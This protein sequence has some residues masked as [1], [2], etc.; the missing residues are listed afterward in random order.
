MGIGRIGVSIGGIGSLPADAERAAVRE[1][2]QLGYE[3][4]WYSESNQTR[5][6]FVHGALLLSWT[7]SIAVASSIASIWARDAVAA[8]AAVRSLGE[9]FPGRFVCGLGV[10]HAPV[11]TGRGHVYAR[12]LT[13]MR[14]YLDA[15][16]GATPAGPE[17]AEPVPV[18]LAALGPLMMRLAG[19][20][21][22]GAHPMFVT[23]DH[24]AWA[25]EILGTE[26]VLAP[27]Q[28][29]LLCPDPI[30]AREIGRAMISPYLGLEG[31]LANWR[32][33]GLGE[34]DFEDGGSDRLIDTLVA[35]GDEQAIA[36]R[37]DAHFEAGADHVALNPIGP[38]PLDQ[39]SRLAPVLIR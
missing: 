4:L 17:P 12:P 6:A 9:A 25:R 28:T 3:A 19:E 2:E 37:I 10:S 11:V 18:I 8:A 22:A 29:V 32:R 36:G 34:S 5:E 30:R 7:E 23:P 20:R 13:A 35:W 15:M 16:E 38:E 26:A 24:T 31:Y 27:K 14:E 39:L 1:I 33:L 21:T